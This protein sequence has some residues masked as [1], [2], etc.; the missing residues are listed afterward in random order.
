[1]EK[2]LLSETVKQFMDCA[3]DTIKAMDGAPEHNDEEKAE[4]KNRIIKLREYLND[5]E[6]SYF[7][8]TSA[9]TIAQVDPAYIAEV[10]HS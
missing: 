9:E 10:G 4:V 7:E 2:M 6:K 5:I 8:N 3:V 1:M